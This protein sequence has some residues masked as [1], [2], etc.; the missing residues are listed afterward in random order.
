MSTTSDL[1]D[2]HGPARLRAL[3][4]DVDG[5]LAETERDGHRPAFNLAFED[6]G[7]HWRWDEARYGELLHVTGGRER[8]LADMAQRADAPATA[9]ERESLARALHARKNEHY[10]RLVAEA[11]LP[12]RPGVAEMIVQASEAGLRQAITTTTSRSNVDALLRVHLGAGWQEHFAAVICGEDVASKKPDPEV[13]LRALRALKLSPLEAMALE[14]SPGGVAAAR[15]ADVPVVVTRSV[16]FAQAP[17]EGATAIGPGLHSR[18]GWTPALRGRVGLVTLDDLQAWFD[19]R[20]TV[21][22]FG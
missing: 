13:Y 5:T 2:P 7:L 11:R 3:F 22:H 18:E 16:Y 1:L 8:I 19:Q 17:I 6:Q 12:L 10:A 14:D 9:S 20:D 4:W 21:S 15:A